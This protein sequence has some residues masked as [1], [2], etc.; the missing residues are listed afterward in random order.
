MTTGDWKVTAKSSPGTATEFGSDDTD[1][2]NKWHRGDDISSTHSSEINSNTTF[3]SSK[4]RIARPADMTAVY[5]IIASA[6]AANRSIT[7]PLLT[8]DDTLVTQ[9][10]AQ[11]L[12]NKTISGSSNTISNIPKSA[13]P[14]SVLH[15]DQNNNLGDFY[16]DI[17]DIAVPTAPA[18]GVAR[19]YYSSATGKLSV[20][21]NGGGISDLEATGGGGGT[22]DPVAVETLENKT[23]SFALNTL[24]NVA[25][26][27][28]AQILTAAK[29][30]TNNTLK[31]QDSGADHAYTVSAPNLSGD[32]TLNLPNLGG[33][34][35]VVTEAHPQT[36]LN[37][38]L[39]TPV[40]ATVKPDPSN[41]LNFPVT[42][43]TLVALTLA[44]TITGKTIDFANNTL[45]GVA[46]LTTAQTLTGKTMTFADNTLT[47]VASTT[48]AQALTA[49]TIDAVDN[50]LLNV[51]L[52]PDRKLWGFWNSLT[53]RSGNGFL[54]GGIAA[55]ATGEA[56]V[57]RTINTDGRRGTFTTGVVADQCAGIRASADG[58][59][60]RLK[61]CRFKAKFKL[62]QTD[63][64]TR[65]YAG[66]SVLGA[67]YLTGD[68]PIATGNGILLL[69]RTTGTNFEIAHNDGTGACVFDDTGIAK[70]TNTHT[71]EI[72]ADNSVPKFQYSI[73]G[74]AFVDITADIPTATIGIVPHMTISTSTTV[75]KSVEIWHMYVDCD[76]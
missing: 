20:I 35:T 73:D 61:N 57:T 31:L 74:A 4:L 14:S 49:K 39:T 54:N 23:I 45:T 50:T 37:K 56:A 60:M 12:T 72:K 26:T 6:I 66:F 33:S 53:A 9:A 48:T 70:D 29:T 5:T 30:F 64:N 34:D 27:N 65:L 58:Q 76:P 22:W 25:S 75:A 19:V 7:L 28:T 16:F 8:G 13:L 1:F 46:S 11:P 47:G 3:R 69:H 62:G 55:A 59:V 38:T 44:Q 63:A 68:D 2:I 32:V 52:Y 18:A 36:L 41:S 15:N 71:I 10:F 21:K 24:I 51:L 43:D 17:G 67:A 42:T 40:I